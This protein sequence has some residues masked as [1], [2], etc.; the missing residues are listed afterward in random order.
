MTENE[1][2]GW[3]HRLDAHEFEEAQELVMDWENMRLSA[4]SPKQLL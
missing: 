4:Q 2:V 1:M 3:H